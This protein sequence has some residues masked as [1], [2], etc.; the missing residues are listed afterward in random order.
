M[1]ER[2]TMEFDV[3]IVGAGPAGLSS[4]MKLAQLAQEKQ[5]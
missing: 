1:V 2:E 4:A 5:Q 3:V